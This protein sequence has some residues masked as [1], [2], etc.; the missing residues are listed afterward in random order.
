M[1]G[2]KRSNMKLADG[3]KTWQGLHGGSKSTPP[4]NT[5]ADGNPT[6]NVTLLR[7]TAL[8]QRTQANYKG[9]WAANIVAQK[10]GSQKRG[11]GI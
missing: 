4:R 3:Q 11:G 10:P 7:K 5:C 1:A 8:W 6:R 2:R 9:K